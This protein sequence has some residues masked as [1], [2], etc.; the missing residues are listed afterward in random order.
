MQASG[1][2]VPYLV[3]F[4]FLLRKFITLSFYFP[5]FPTVQFLLANIESKLRRV[6]S[7]MPSKGAQVYMRL[8]F[9]MQNMEKAFIVLFTV[10]GCSCSGPLILMLC[11]LFPSSFSGPFP[12]VQFLFANVQSKLRRVASSMPS[13]GTSVRG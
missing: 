11:D 5:T 12:T 4:S 13:K 8:R 7:S 2:L 3:A 9:R 10:G 6:A 1:P